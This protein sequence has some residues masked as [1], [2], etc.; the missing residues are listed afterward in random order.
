[1]DLRKG[2]AMIIHTQSGNLANNTPSVQKPETSA[3]AA[4]DN[5]ELPSR[6]YS[7]TEKSLLRVDVRWN[8]VFTWQAP[9]MLMSYSSILFLMGLTIYVITPLYDG[10]AFDVESKVSVAFLSLEKP[11]SL[12]IS[13]SEIDTS[14]YKAAIFYIVFLVFGGGVF[15]WCSFWAYR[16]VDLHGE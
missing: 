7:K 10:R 9:I 15:V 5:R 1:M 12:L 11:P 6:I 13:K 16:F 4:A 8:M 3:F 2:L 14:N